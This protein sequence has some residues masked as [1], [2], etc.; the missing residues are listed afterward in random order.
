MIQLAQAISSHQR[1]DQNF[2]RN[3]QLRSGSPTGPPQDPETPKTPKRVSLALGDEIKSPRSEDTKLAMSN[4][5][6]NCRLFFAKV[7][8]REHSGNLYETVDSLLIFLI[9]TLIK[10]LQ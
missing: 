7:E 8:A 3:L 5:H 9:L 10:N 2:L 4:F 1:S 6:T